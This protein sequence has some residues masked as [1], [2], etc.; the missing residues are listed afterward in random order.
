M[1]SMLT[2]ASQRVTVSLTLRRLTRFK[3]MIGFV[4]GITFVPRLDPRISLIGK[5]GCQTYQDMRIGLFL[6]KASLVVPGLMRWLCIIA[7]QATVLVQR[8]LMRGP[9]IKWTKT[10][11]V[12]LFFG[13]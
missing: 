1:S 5:L 10:N 7:K 13:S 6:F 9:S 11:L 2:Q 3:R 12:A 4:K 8:H